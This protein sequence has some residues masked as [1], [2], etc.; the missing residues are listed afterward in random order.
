MSSE[1]RLHHAMTRGFLIG[2][3]G[4]VGSVI[5]ATAGIAILVALLTKIDFI[6]FVGDFVRQ[7]TLYVSARGVH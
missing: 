7:I 1:D 3:A 4:G 6:P 5:G 2:I